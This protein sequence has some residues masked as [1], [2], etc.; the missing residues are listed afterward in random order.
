MVVTEDL[1]GRDY[2]SMTDF[3]REEI[4]TFLSVGMGIKR[5]FAAKEDHR[6]ILPARTLFMVF[7]NDSLRTRNSFEA[8]MTQLGGHAHFL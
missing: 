4:E 2:L 1:T 8:G 5:R 3:T 7:Y 6:N